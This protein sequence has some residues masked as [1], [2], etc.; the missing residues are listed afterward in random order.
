MN[1]TNKSFTFEHQMINEN[2][3]HH[4][5]PLYWQSKNHQEHDFQYNGMNPCLKAFLHT[6]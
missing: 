4:N 6:K 1:F 3:E 5:V 2:V